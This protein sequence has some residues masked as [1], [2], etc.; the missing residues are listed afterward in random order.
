MTIRAFNMENDFLNLFIDKVNANSRAL[1]IFIC[2][3]RWFAVRLDLMICCLTFVT[4]I[5]SVALRK[6]MDPASVALGLSYC[7][8]LT[9]LFQWG[10]RQSAETENFMTSAERIDEY[11]HIPPEPNFYQGE[12]KPPVDWP[13]EGRIEFE[14]YKLRYRP[15]LEP[16]LKGI[17]F[18]NRSRE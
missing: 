2:S 14:D 11:S 4:A 7:I 8:A 13:T 6:S 3:G 9:S 15:E 16:V 10:V 1:I 18:K 12:L 17:K 5:L